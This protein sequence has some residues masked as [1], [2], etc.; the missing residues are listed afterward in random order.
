MEMVLRKNSIVESPVYDIDSQKY[1]DKKS[2][3]RYKGKLFRDDICDECR[4]D[5]IGVP[6]KILFNQKGNVI[7]C[8]FLDRMDTP[9][10]KEYIEKN[11]K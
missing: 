11:I 8:G 6:Y 2:D 7:R 10:V 1:K 4:K 5:Y 3:D 9:T